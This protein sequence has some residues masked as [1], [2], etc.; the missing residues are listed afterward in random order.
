M[1][2]LE[3]LKK[4]IFIADITKSLELIYFENLEIRVNT[5]LEKSQEVLYSLNVLN[6]PYK[7][8]TPEKGNIPKEI[9]VCFGV[10]VELKV[11]CLL[12][13]ILKEIYG[14]EFDL[15]ISY[16]N[17]PKGREKEIILGTYILKNYAFT[18]ISE[19]IPPTD[20]LTYSFKNV[21]WEELKSNFPNMNY[22]EEGYCI[23]LDYDSEHLDYDADY[24]YDD[25]GGSYEK[26]GG[27]NGWSDDAIDDAFEGDPMNTWNVD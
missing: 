20:F 7:E 6:I 4:L 18:N 2:N 15:Y 8:F 11:V 1:V 24:D 26:Y 17:Q 23:N 14:D 16:A 9:N 27:Y 22:F 25:Y 12:T 5:L 13:Y 10:E 3:L 19:S 21:N